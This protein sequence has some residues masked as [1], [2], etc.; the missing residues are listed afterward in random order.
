MNY[1]FYLVDFDAT[2]HINYF[3]DDCDFAKFNDE[4]NDMM[5]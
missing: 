1:L 3:E 5:I 4:I 2:I